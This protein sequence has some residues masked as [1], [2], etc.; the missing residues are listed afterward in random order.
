MN[1]NSNDVFES[2]IKRLPGQKT[3]GHDKSILLID[4]FNFIHYAIL[5]NLLVSE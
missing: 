5:M 4:S 3:C 2:A 1:V